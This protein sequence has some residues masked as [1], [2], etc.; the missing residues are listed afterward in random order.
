MVKRIPF[1]FGIGLLAMLFSFPFYLHSQEQSA[2]SKEN[3]RYGVKAGVNFAEL[4]GADAIPESDRKVGYSFGVYATY[5]LSKEVKIQP[6]IIWSLQGEKSKVK[7]RYDISY[8]NIPVMVKWTHGPFYTEVGPQLGL[9]TIST[10]TAVPDSIRLKNF[11]TFDV[12]F[13]LGAGVTF[14][15]DWMLGIRY[16]QGLTNLVQG[17]DLKNSVIYI[18][19][20]YRVF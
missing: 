19:I 9:Q 6:E 15:E 18:G 7:G 20:A 14:W 8:L 17:R 11:E 16:S 1:P 3:T 5:K 10:S 4:F 2:S 13:N 12:S